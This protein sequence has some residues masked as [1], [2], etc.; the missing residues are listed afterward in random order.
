MGFEEDK[1][2][3]SM[4]IGERVLLPTARDAEDDTIL[5]TDGFSCKTQIEQGDTGRRALHTAQV[6]KMAL[7]HG[8]GGTPRG[9]RPES[10][11][12]DTVLDGDGHGL[13]AAA[14][15]GAAAAGG[16]LLW[17]LRRRLG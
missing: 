8:T 17:G 5:L 4:K 14:V 7:D 3:L 6:L 10:E 15:T 2:E 9:E 16:V 12:P 13:K 1:H 11:Y